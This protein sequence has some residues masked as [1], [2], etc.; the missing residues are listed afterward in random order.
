[1]VELHSDDVA[2]GLSSGGAEQPCPGI[3]SSLAPL[4]VALPLLQLGIP[5]VASEAPWLDLYPSSDTSELLSLPTGGTSWPLLAGA[6]LGWGTTTTT[7]E[8]EA[9]SWQLVTGAVADLTL[10]L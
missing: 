8:E 4:M 5:D 1:M 7:S 9:V 6:L 3:V 10:V 2:T